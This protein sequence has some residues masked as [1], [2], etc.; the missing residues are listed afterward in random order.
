[1]IGYTSSTAFEWQ[2]YSLSLVVLELKYIIETNLAYKTE[3]SIYLKGGGHEHFHIAFLLPMFSLGEAKT[4]NS[5]FKFFSECIKVVKYA[6]KI[7]NTAGMHFVM[8]SS[9]CGIAYKNVTSGTCKAIQ[10]V[11]TVKMSL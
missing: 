3:F 7:V 8:V 6:V 9:V 4:Q 5:I 11:F 2:L 1:M 10:E